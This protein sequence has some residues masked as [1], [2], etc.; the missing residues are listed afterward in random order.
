M[1]FAAGERWSLMTRTCCR[2]GSTLSASTLS[3]TR[4]ES[5]RE[6]GPVDW[7]RRA[8][9]LSTLLNSEHTGDIGER[10]LPRPA[11]CTLWIFIGQFFIT[12][13]SCRVAAARLIAHRLTNDQRRCSVETVAN[14]QAHK[15]LRLQTGSSLRVRRR[16]RV[17]AASV[18]S[19]HDSG[20]GTPLPPADDELSSTEP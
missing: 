3:L 2:Q 10:R 4:R 9:Y 14:Y 7:R 12:D 6:T 16:R 19:I 8:S 18:K 11:P 1:R 13:H 15:R 17:D 20:S 5:G